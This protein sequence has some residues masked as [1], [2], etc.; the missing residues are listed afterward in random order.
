MK[1]EHQVIASAANMD[2]ALAAGLTRAQL[3][4][5]TVARADR[6]AGVD[7]SVDPAELAEALRHPGALLFDET[8]VHR[9]RRR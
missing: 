3:L 5:L 8:F 2:R 1:P 6:A 9:E 4:V 7:L